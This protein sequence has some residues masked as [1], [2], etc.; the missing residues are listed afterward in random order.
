MFGHIDSKGSRFLVNNY[1]DYIQIIFPQ[2][3]LGRWT[4][5]LFVIV[6]AFP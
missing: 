2:Q 3:E 6:G 1:P 4:L 5:P